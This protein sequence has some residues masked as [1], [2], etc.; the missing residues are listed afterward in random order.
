MR[1]MGDT[2][3][4]GTVKVGKAPNMLAGPHTFDRLVD[5]RR[6][7]GLSGEARVM[8]PEGLRLFVGCANVNG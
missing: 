6:A 2:A 3:P 8:G 5:D 7:S 4:D 1:Q